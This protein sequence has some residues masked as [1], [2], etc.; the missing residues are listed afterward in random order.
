MGDENA[1]IP[2]GEAMRD[3]VPLGY[4]EFLQTCERAIIGHL[5]QFTSLSGTNDYFTDLDTDITYN[6]ILWKSNSLRI[7]GL[8]RKT[9]VGLEVD[10]QGMKIFALP[11]DT[12]FG[13][14]FLTDVEVGLL[15][16]CLITRFRA[17]WPVVTGNLLTDVSAPP[18][19]VFKM[20][21]GYV[22]KIEKGGQTHVELKVKSPL[23]KLEINMPRNYYQPGCLWTLFEPGCTVDKTLN[24]WHVDAVT[25]TSS[26]T[27]IAPVG[28]IAVPQGADDINNY[29]QGRLLFTS[30]ANSGLLTLIDHNDAVTLFLAYPLETAPA[31]GDTF[32]FYVGCSKSFDTCN[33]KFSNSLNFRGFDK[34]PPI[35]ISI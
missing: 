6:S 34:V 27:A 12:L 14:N 4:I 31:P 22:S 23:V 24:E 30:G 13:A 26:K 16:G 29:A 11:T 5:Y 19:W 20:F 7:D 25:F 8:R 1:K 9:S 32:T 18:A 21:M 35:A 33:R 2:L 28:G 17:V 15:D 10:E 3:N